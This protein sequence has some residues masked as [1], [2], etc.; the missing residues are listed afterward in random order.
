M[1][2]LVI[3]LL[4]LGL[5]GLSPSADAS[6]ALWGSTVGNVGVRY[7][8]EDA[9]CTSFRSAGCPAQAALAHGATI[10]VVDVRHLAGRT[11]EFTWSDATMKAYDA[12]GRPFLF[13]HSQM[14][15]YV[16]ESCAVH[17]PTDYP[18]AL[19]VA[20]TLTTKPELR[21]ATF[22]LPRSARWIVA[23]PMQNAADVTWWAQL[24][25]PR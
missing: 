24:K 21:S 17:V 6:P 2:R 23:E 11:L 15:F 13:P 18:N 5:A 9:A 20:F 12:A 7:G 10:S 22:T 1:K 19:P 8:C 16:I 3:G 25:P 14:M 4:A